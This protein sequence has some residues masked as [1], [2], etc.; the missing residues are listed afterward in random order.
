VFLND[1][2]FVERE[3]LSPLLARL[4]RDERVGAAGPM[5]LN[6]DGSLQNAGSLVT[7]AGGTAEY[8]NGE[9][10]NDPRFE[11]RR[12]VDYVAGACFLIRRRLFDAI[13]GFDPRYHPMY[14]EDA[15]LCLAIRA[16]GYMIEY[17]P[18]SVVTHVGG[19]SGFALREPGVPLRNRH[20]FER[21]WRARLAARPFAPLHTPRRLVGARDAP[22]ATRILVVGDKPGRAALARSLA[23][24]CSR[25]QIT[26][27]AETTASDAALAA[28]GIESA[29]VEDWAG[30]LGERRLHYDLVVVAEGS[31]QSRLVAATQP[32]AARLDP[33]VGDPRLVPDLAEAGVAVNGGRIAGTSNA[34]RF[35]AL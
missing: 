29:A 22:S 25:A 3:W 28:A 32:Q 34:G 1:D 18:G 27:A 19:A 24:V 7:R 23:S 13:G 16:R 15:D 30:W 26:L 11:F 21:R 12:I 20:T 17:E 35:R 4:E 8:G 14:F 6:V 10:A 9:P 2:V 33:D 5:I 31:E